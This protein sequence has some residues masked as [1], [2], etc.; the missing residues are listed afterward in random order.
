MLIQKR[1]TK[2]L[3]YYKVEELISSGGW[4]RVRLILNSGR[5]FLTSHNEPT[6]VL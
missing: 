1:S 4:G 3:F 6:I 5:V 2:Y